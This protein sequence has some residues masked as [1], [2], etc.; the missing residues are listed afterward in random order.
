MSEYDP[1]NTHEL[2]VQSTIA[3]AELQASYIAI[4]LTMVFAYTT[5]AYIAGKQLSKVQVFI[6]T[7]VY[8]LASFYVVALIVSMTASMVVYQERI[9]ELGIVVVS[10]V[11]ETTISLWVDVVVWPSLMAASLIFMWNV[12]RE[13]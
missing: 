8:L 5:V 6:A 1:I 4:Y 9:K 7:F 13:K 2:M 11:D 3:L 12:R 10:R